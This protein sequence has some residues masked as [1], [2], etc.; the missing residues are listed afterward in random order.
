MVERRLDRALCSRLQERKKLSPAL[1]LKIAK[2]T[3]RQAAVL[4]GPS[5]AQLLSVVKK[6]LAVYRRWRQLADDE[7]H[8]LEEGPLKP[9]L[10]KVIL[11]AQKYAAACHDRADRGAAAV[12]LLTSLQ[13]LL[14]VM[15]VRFGG[16]GPA[17]S[18]A[19][20]VG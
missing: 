15:L 20:A 19:P 8:E 6:A 3:R 14:D 7:R 17:T 9:Y 12:E 11:S 16:S 5:K 4:R 18:G 13:T 10:E 2:F 1:L